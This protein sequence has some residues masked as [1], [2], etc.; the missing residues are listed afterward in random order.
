MAPSAPEWLEDI[1]DKLRQNELPTIDLSHPRLDDVSAK[2]FVNAMVDNTSLETL[3]VSCYAMVDDGAYAIGLMLQRSKK[4]RRL[5]LK[6]VRNAREMKIFFQLLS[7]NESIT[8]LSLRHCTICPKGADAIASFLQLHSRLNEIRVTDSQCS[9]RGFEIIC[10]NGLCRTSAPLD[11][12]YW[13]GGELEG[14]AMAQQL[15][16]VA[17]PSLNVSNIQELILSENDLGDDGMVLLARGF[18]ERKS[19]IRRLDLRSN[20]LTSNGALAIQG[21]VVGNNDLSW[22]SLSHNPLG[23]SGVSIIASGLHYSSCSLKSLQ[24]CATGVQDA[25]ASDIA[26]MLQVNTSLKELNL[27]FNGVDIQGID[28]IGRALRSNKTLLRLDLRRNNISDAGAAAISK[29]LPFMGCLKQLNIAKNGIG[30]SGTS[31]LL[32]GL[33]SNVELEFLDLDEQALP[34]PVTQELSNYIRLNRAGRRIFRASNVP[35]ALWPYIYG[36]IS[37]DVDMVGVSCKTLSHRF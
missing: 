33:R 25:G 3:I 4:I 11:K 34:T 13:V 15:V 31:S 14:E 6:D 20:S 26:I 28:D 36:R 35:N 8:E 18:I 2:I 16:D 19:R 32:Q 22:L 5:Q 23:D 29:H 9:R 10:Q 21:L 1:C 27:S 17:S 24:L 12:L 7:K 30:L 37:G